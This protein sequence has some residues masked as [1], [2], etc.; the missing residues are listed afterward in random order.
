MTSIKAPLSCGSI[1]RSRSQRS[2]KLQPALNCRLFLVM[3][4]VLTIPAE[5]RD[6]GPVIFSR[7]RRWLIRS[8][9]DSPGASARVLFPTA[10]EDQFGSGRYQLI[11]LAGF[12]YSLSELS[13]GSFFQPLVRYDF[14]VG[15]NANSKHVSRFRFS[16]TL[17]IALPKRW[18]LTLYP[19]QDIVLNNIGGH[20]WFVPADFLIG[21]H[22][23]DRVVAS[24]E[25]SIPL[26]KDFNL[27]DFK[28]EG[29]IGF[30]F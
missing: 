9:S 20:R 11:P 15:G 29:R 10:N 13:S 8:R 23:S 5:K 27:Y 22:L 18:Y 30:S 3:R 25:I 28:L 16:P 17:N 7:K 2:G 4:P 1:A 24:L 12:R 26:I 14:D 21:R 6:L 19:S